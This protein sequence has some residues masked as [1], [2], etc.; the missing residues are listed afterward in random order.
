MPTPIGPQPDCLQC[1]A[2][3]PRRACWQHR[4]PPVVA[5]CEARRRAL[6][7]A[8]M[9]VLSYEASAARGEP[10]QAELRAARAEVNRRRGELCRD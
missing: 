8:R 4:P 6:A 2:L 1:R 9:A 7:G 3:G 5:P 10:V